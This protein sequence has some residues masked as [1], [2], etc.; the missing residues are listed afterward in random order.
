MYLGKGRLQHDRLV[1]YLCQPRVDEALVYFLRAV[2]A[3]ELYNK[4]DYYMTF[5][6]GIDAYRYA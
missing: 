6:P 1:E 3:L 2:T 4:Q 5:V